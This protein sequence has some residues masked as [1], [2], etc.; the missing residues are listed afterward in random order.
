MP[1]APYGLAAFH[2]R[3]HIALLGFSFEILPAVVKGFST[4]EGQF[5]F[6]D[7]PLVKVQL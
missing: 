6:G 7:A 2:G 1:V 5:N 3:F 4:G